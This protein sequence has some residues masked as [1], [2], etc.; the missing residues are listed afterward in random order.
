M[1]AGPTLIFDKSTLQML[2]RNEAM[3]LDHFFISNITPLFFVE[4]L[5]DL[6]KKVGA[7]RT[8]EQVVGNLAYKT[9][10]LQSS[11]AV[12]H[13]GVLQAELLGIQ[14]ATMDGRIVRAGGRTV[15]LEGNSGVI[16]QR[17]T[18][19]EAF[20]RWQA[21]EFLDLDRQIA[22]LWRRSLSKVNYDEIYQVFQGWF[23]GRKKP[24]NLSEVKSLVDRYIDG[25]Q[26]NTLLF[27]M[28]FFGVPQEAQQEIVRRWQRAGKPTVKEFA[29]YL[30]Y[31]LSVDLFFYLAIASDHISRVRPA[32]KA[33]NKVDVAYLYYLPFC[34]VFASNDN[35]HARI[36]PHFLR[37]DQT[38]IKGADLK[39][40]LKRLN[41]H[42]SNLPV[43]VKAQG[44]IRFASHPPADFSFLITQLWD[45]HLPK[46]RASRTQE[47]SPRNEA[48]DKKIV[49][50]I[51]RLDR[52]AKDATPTA[53]W[54]PDE[55][56]FML[57]KRD[58][59]INKGDW[60][61][62]PAGVENN[63]R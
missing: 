39:A 6:E 23:A 28:D 60:R 49:D 35:L 56:G 51:N 3:W 48:D 36:V 43:E 11:P 4:T 46:W 20:D 34:M 12:H 54:S 18:E 33:D 24:Q 22:K 50:E 13:L 52:E 59:L 62:F 55:V 38:F 47:N 9:P 8:P 7:G 42:Y 19:E 17:T 15:A 25:N 27:G 57:I 14:Q 41:E 5:A 1:P 31:L 10:D 40:D 29:P 16:F 44:T 53:G 2:D 32:N 45:K 61:R 63:K 30:R 37:E 58:V 26:E 21:G